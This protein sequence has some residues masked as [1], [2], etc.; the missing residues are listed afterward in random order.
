[1]RRL[2]VVS[3]LVNGATG[4]TQWQQSFESPLTDVFAVQG[5]IAARVAGA[6][7]AQLGAAESRNLVRRPTANPAAWDAY[8]KGVAN[9]SLDAGALRVS[10]AHLENAVALDSTLIEAW[11]ALSRATGRLYAN[12]GRDIRLAARS[13]EAIERAMALDSTSA[14]AHA[15]AAAYYTLGE[16][17]GPDPPR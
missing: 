7:G 17:K 15:A 4:A 6:L 1:S 2:Q 8:L 5:Q 9:T 13:R 12:G 14:L 3:E 16:T 11:V 10:T